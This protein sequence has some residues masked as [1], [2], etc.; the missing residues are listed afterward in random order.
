MAKL[1]DA[2][3][4]RSLANVPEW[5]LLGDT[6]Q[7]TYAFADFGASMRFVGKV[8][9]AA[10]ADRH[11]PDILIRYN[12]VTLTLST[13]DAGGLSAKDFALAWKCDGFAGSEA[14]AAATPAAPKPSRKPKS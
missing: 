1:S 12:K 6:I 11:H 3:I 2:E 9:Q 5:A 7:R 4:E 14:P 13:H 10:E 8:A